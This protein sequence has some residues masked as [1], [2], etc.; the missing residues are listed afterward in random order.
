MCAY[1]YNYMYVHTC[2]STIYATKKVTCQSW[3]SLL[4]MCVIIP[5]W[6]PRA[7]RSRGLKCTLQYTVM[8]SQSILLAS[9]LLG[10][11]LKE[12]IWKLK[13]LCTSTVFQ[14]SRP[15]DN[16]R[17]M[18]H[19]HHSQHEHIKKFIN[20]LQPNFIYSMEL[21]KHS[22]N[23]VSIHGDNKTQH[24]FLIHSHLVS[25]TLSKF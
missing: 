17:S 8:A 21:S 9:C 2:K 15:S 19:W 3:Q 4:R 12:G 5:S 20:Q 18:K 22:W 7:A 24:H 1:V 11:T 10:V 25:V 23:L 16:V 14:C 13:T 6:H